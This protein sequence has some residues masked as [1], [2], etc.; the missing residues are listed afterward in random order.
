[1]AKEKKSVTKY[2]IEIPNKL[3]NDLKAFSRENE[4]TMSSVVRT[5]IKKEIYVGKPIFRKLD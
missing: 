4:V 1:M 2:T 5:G 3:F